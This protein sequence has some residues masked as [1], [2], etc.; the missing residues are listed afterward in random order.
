MQPGVA[1]TTVRPSLT[2][3]PW[4]PT[5][6]VAAIIAGVVLGGIGLDGV[7]AAPSAGTVAIG[8]TATIKAAP[9]WVR[10][11]DGSGTVVLQKAN[12]QLVVEAEPYT[13]SA[14]SALSDMKTSLASAQEQISFGDEQDG[15]ISGRESAMIG[16]EAIVSGSSGSGTVDG[17]II[18]L[19]YGGEVVVLEVITPQGDLGGVEDDV[20]AMIA[21]V[22]VGQ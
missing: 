5:L 8:G 18:C 3:Q 9:G 16:F 6:V 12:A 1:P 10:A 21:S 14:S 2:R 20:K 4:L 17:E 11:D 15:T 22:E 13:G 19:K 7:L